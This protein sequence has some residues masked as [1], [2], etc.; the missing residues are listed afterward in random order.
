L[1][2]AKTN[3]LELGDVK[4]V[5]MQPEF[6]LC[7]QFPKEILW[8]LPIVAGRFIEHHK[9]P[10]HPI[11]FPRLIVA[12]IHANSSLGDG[13]WLACSWISEFAI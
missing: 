6:K 12:P 3:T 5:D 9:P 4:I 11:L 1:G 13:R 8:D 7:P 2:R 10:L